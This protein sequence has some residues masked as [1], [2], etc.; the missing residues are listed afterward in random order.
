MGVEYSPAID[1]FVDHSRVFWENSHYAVVIHKTASA[2]NAKQQAAFF[3]TNAEKKSAHFV[4]GQDGTVVQ[5]VHLVDGAGG[6]CCVEHGYDSFWAGLDPMF[7]GSGTGNNLNLSTISI[8]MCDPDLNNATPVTPEQ[9]IASFQLVKWL[10]QK[11][12]IP[13]SHIKTHQSIDPISRANCPGN[14]PM[15]ELIA[16]VQGGVMS[17]VPQGWS[18]D[19]TTLTAPNGKKVVKGFR[20]YILDHEHA[21]DDQPADEEHGASPLEETNTSLGGG[22]KQVFY[23][24]VLE[25]VESSNVVIEGYI[26]VE[27]LHVLADRN[28]LRTVM[29]HLQQQLGALQAGLPRAD[30]NNAIATITKL[31]QDLTGLTS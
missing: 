13:A 16:Y 4:V 22:T 21:E 1:M 28:N 26:G 15:A 31:A 30:I 23:K 14:Y 10:C 19:G 29:A 2:G 8:E 25:W 17:G 24:S 6:N 12:N 11:Y 18:D 3:A 9:K 7:V 27:Y 5:C 20:Q